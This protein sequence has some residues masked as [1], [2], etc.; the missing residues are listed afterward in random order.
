MMAETHR[1]ILMKRRH[2]LATCAASMAPLPLLAQQDDYKIP[3]LKK[4]WAGGDPHMHE[5]FGANWYYTWWPGGDESKKARFMPMVKEEKHIHMLGSIES[6]KRVDCILGYNEPER[7]DQANMKLETCLDLWPRIAEVAERKGARL[8]SPAPSSDGGGMAFLDAF[9]SAAR[10]RKLKVD[11][12]CLHYYRSRD[13]S[14]FENFCS[15]IAKKY[16]LPVWITEFN[17]WSGTERENYEFLKRSLRYLEQS[18]EVE[19]YAYFNTKGGSSTGL[20]K[21]DGSV[22]DLGKLYQDAGT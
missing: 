4:G 20:T 9:M 15:G 12:V 18:S 19:R 16:R 21:E 22:S 3:S 8:G 17:G 6:M 14:D 13:P 10:T 5:L 7:K 1:R 2:F 11:F